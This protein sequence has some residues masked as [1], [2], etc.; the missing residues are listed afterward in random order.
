ML[1]RP[2]QR[3]F[4]DRTLGKLS[5]NDNTLGIAPTGTGKT[6]IFSHLL[7]RLL[8]KNTEKKALVVAHRDEITEQNLEKFYKVGNK[9]FIVSNANIDF[10]IF[11]KSG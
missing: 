5:K 1:L 7:G 3:E 8:T 11:S 4:I 9:A 6:I 10:R 2:R